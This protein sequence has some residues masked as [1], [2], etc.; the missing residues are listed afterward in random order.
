VKWFTHRPHKPK[1]LGSTPRPHI[2][3]VKSQLRELSNP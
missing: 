3:Q 1:T 2:N